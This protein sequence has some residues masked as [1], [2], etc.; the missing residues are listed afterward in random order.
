MN[1]KKIEVRTMIYITG[2]THGSFERIANFCKM[3]NTTEK[4]IMIILGDAEINYEG[5]LSD[6]LK[7]DYLSFFPITFL[8]VHGNHEQRPSS[9]PSYKQKSWHGGTVY[10]EDDFPNIL[11]AKDGEI[12]DLNGKK[13]LVIGGAYSVDMYYRLM[14]GLPWF[15]DEQ[16]SDEIKMFVE[17]QLNR[18]DWSVDVVLTHTVPLKY[19]PVEMYLDGIDQSK[20]D[21]STEEWLDKIEDKLNYKKWYCGH[22]HTEKII[23][24]LEIMY[25]NFGDFYE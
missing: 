17:K 2:D 22:Y 12:Y 18:V 14:K 20:V 21:K 1:L 23:D 16:P 24:K 4:D 13:T 19:E 6:F 5:G 11:F 7:K 3:M 10:Y 8:C 15:H 25:Q 9:I